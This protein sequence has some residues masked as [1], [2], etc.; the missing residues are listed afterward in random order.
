MCIRDRILNSS[1]WGQVDSVYTLFVVL[2]LYLLTNKETIKSYFV[3]AV[4]IFIKPQAFMFMPL[5]IFGIIEN[6]FL[7]KFDREKFIKN[8]LWGLGAVAMLFLL[9]LPFGLGNVINQ[10][11]ETLSSYPYLTVNAFNLWGALG[12]NWTELSLSL[13]HI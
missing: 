1:L 4:C 10:Y 9:A 13:I 6:V 5:L 2:M 7:P 11:K 3:F 12:Q 8:L